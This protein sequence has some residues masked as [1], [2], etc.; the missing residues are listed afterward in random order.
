[1]KVII[2]SIL[3]IFCLMLQTENVFGYVRFF[4]AKNPAF[5]GHCYHKK[6][7]AIRAGSAKYLKKTCEIIECSRSLQGSISG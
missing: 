2:I 6:H 1:M 5:P 4:N 7:G 3:V